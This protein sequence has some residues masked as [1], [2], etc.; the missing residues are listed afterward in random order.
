MQPPT[1]NLTPVPKSPKLFPYIQNI[2]KQVTAPY[3]MVKILTHRTNETIIFQIRSQNNT[4]Q[5]K[6]IINYQ[7]DTYQPIK[8]NKIEIKSERLLFEIVGIFD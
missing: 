2:D 4:I 3:T 6:I 5:S 7:Y 8:H 1:G